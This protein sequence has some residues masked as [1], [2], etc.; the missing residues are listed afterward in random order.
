MLSRL[1][2]PVAHFLKNQTPQPAPAQGVPE[3]LAALAETRARKADL[4]RRE[5][6][7]IVATQAKLRE[8]QE[9]LEDLRRKVRDNGIETDG[10]QSAAPAAAE[11]ATLRPSQPALLSN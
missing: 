4:E 11:G 2:A 9:A 5:R 6:E 10:S 7:L 8:Q 1:A 3:L